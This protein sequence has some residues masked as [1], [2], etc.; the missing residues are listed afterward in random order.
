MPDDQRKAAAQGRRR[1][2]GGPPG[3]PSAPLPVERYDMPPVII[4]SGGRFFLLV[5][6]VGIA[7]GILYYLEQTIGFPA[8]A[9]IPIYATVGVLGC[10]AL[11]LIWGA[12]RGR[13]RMVQTM[14]ERIGAITGAGLAIEEAEGRLTYVN[15]PFLEFLGLCGAETREEEDL[16]VMYV[17]RM[18]NEAARAFKQLREDAL[19]G[20]ASREIIHLP[21]SGRDPLR[22]VLGAVPG[23]AGEV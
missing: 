11:I 8:E 12:L 7:F 15:G 21:R 2:A 5:L 23:N 18:Q 4:G 17:F 19:G 9:R 6:F 16:W 14:V 3:A 1:S 20:V 13:R 22:L 10:V